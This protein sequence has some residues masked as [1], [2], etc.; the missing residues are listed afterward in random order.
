MEN[1]E[2]GAEIIAEHDGWCLWMDIWSISTLRRRSWRSRSLPMEL[3]WPCVPR[4][5]ACF[6]NFVCVREREGVGWAWLLQ[7]AAKPLTGSQSWSWWPFP[8]SVQQAITWL[9]RNQQRKVVL[10]MSQHAYFRSVQDV[11]AESKPFWVCYQG[12]HGRQFYCQ[13]LTVVAKPWAVL[14][15]LER[16]SRNLWMEISRD[17]ERPWINLLRA[18][19]GG[20]DGHRQHPERMEPA[21]QQIGVWRGK[22]APMYIVGRGPSGD[23]LAT[24]VPSQMTEYHH[25]L[26]NCV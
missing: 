14:Q 12:M 17:H 24:G 1:K 23:V 7:H 3:C 5:C 25:H 18:C 16:K 11:L 15:W 22:P 8:S 26:L 10:V 13:H 6:F 4:L 19:W 20:I 21:A 9:R 2:L